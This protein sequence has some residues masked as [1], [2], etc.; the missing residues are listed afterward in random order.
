MKKK[1]IEIWKKLSLKR[2]GEILEDD[3][4]KIDQEIFRKYELER[5]K[6]YYAVCKKLNLTLRISQNL[7]TFFHFPLS[8]KKINFQL[9]ET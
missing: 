3:N 1:K 9:E 6:Y 7:S 5:M 2:E 4:S 8:H